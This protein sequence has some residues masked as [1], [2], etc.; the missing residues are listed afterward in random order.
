MCAGSGALST[1]PSRLALLTYFLRLPPELHCLHPIT[2]TLGSEQVLEGLSPS[3]TP[4]C[5]AKCLPH[6]K[7]Q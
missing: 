6:T 4:C 1:Q 5:L 2:R 3:P 7:V